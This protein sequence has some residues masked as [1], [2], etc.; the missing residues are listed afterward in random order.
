MDAKAT[1]QA[2]LFH[3]FEQDFSTWWWIDEAHSCRDAP[4]RG[5]LN[6]SPLNHLQNLGVWNLS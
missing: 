5:C 6:L 3:F 1:A 2:N 4:S